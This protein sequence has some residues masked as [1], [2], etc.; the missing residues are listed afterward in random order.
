LKLISPL[1]SHPKFFESCICNKNTVQLQSAIKVSVFLDYMSAA[2]EPFWV[3]TLV[4]P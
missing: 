1:I 3:P 4:V 2:S